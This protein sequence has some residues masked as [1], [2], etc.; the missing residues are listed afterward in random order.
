[1]CV[2]SVQLTAGAQIITVWMDAISISTCQ[3]TS[4]ESVQ[5]SL[6]LMVAVFLQYLTIEEETQI[7]QQFQRD[8]WRRNSQVMWS[9]IP[10]EYA[11]RWADEHGMQTLT[12]AM[13]PLMISEHPLCLKGR[14]S[15]K[16][17]SKYV[18]GASAVF[19]WQI[20]RGEKITV[21][22]PPPPER[23]HPSGLTNYQA[24]EEPIL[25]GEI[26]GSAV[27][28]IEM[29]HPTVKGAENFCYQIWP[30]DET[31]TWIAKF[32]MLTLKKQRWRMVKMIPK[33]MEI[34][35]VTKTTPKRGIED[36]VVPAN[37]KRR[38]EKN[39]ATARK[40]EKVIKVKNVR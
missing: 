8:T 16:Q 36:G 29:V 34:R 31:R 21:L 10:R 27:S 3:P 15:L 12:T 28:R 4:Y 26:G 18:K 9:G 7:C 23:F 20:S 33:R 5:D 14:K 32:G 35:E 17:W 22:S 39:V 30:V 13:G 38:P 11:Q 24:I 6:S 19:A 2:Y 25:K 37:R 40:K 1:M